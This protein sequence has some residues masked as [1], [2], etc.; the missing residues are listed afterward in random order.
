MANESKQHDTE[1]NILVI[2]ST[3]IKGQQAT[4]YGEYC[5]QHHVVMEPI[6]TKR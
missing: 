3:L 5:S 1:N 4:C 2:E 6:L